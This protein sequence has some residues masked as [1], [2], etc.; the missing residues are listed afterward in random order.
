MAP[1]IV[2]SPGGEVELLVGGRGGPRI[3]TAV[4]QAIVNVIDHGMPLAD[5][6][7]APRI[8]H[9]AL[10]DVLEYEKGGVPEDVMAR[11][12]A[13]GY[14]TRPAG[15]GSLTAIRRTAKGWE[16][17]YDPRSHGLAEGY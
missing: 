3:I 4:V 15:T 10:P 9:Q 12:R 1:T 8:H 13:M 5:A 14:T 11:L 6:L 16:G 2:V 7:G 17:M